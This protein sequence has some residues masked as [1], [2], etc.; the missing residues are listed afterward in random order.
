MR[1]CKGPGVVLILP[2]GWSKRQGSSRQKQ[3]SSEQGSMGFN[4]EGGGSHRAVGRRDETRG[5]SQVPRMED[6]GWSR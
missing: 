1:P 5:W 3:E 4:P 6:T 2:R